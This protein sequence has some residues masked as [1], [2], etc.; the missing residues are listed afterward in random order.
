M[1]SSIFGIGV[2]GLNAANLG[3]TTTGHN[4]SNAN[5]AGYSRQSIIQSAPYPQL[6]GSGYV[7]LGTRVDT[8]VRSY[9][10]FLTRQVMTTQAKS[11]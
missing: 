2:S 4:I 3:L 8:I 5:T 11:G 7:G 10:Q 6:S 1:G 9:D